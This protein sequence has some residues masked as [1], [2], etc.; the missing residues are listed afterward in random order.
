MLGI[1]SLEGNPF[2]YEGFC[3]APGDLYCIVCIRERDCERVK[4]NLQWLCCR[5]YPFILL[6][7]KK[8]GI[9]KL[10]VDV[11]QIG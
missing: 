3:I 7:N 9:K 6:D 1:F 4:R 8:E 2:L 10:F 11:A 5:L